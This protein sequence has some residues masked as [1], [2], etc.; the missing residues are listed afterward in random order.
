M[1]GSRFSFLTRWQAVLIM[2]LTVMLIVAGSEFSRS[3]TPSKVP[4]PST[5]E[6]A[7][8]V[9]YRQFITRVAQGDAYYP[10]AADELRRGNYP[11]RPFV[12]FRLPLLTEVSAALGTDVMLGLLWG[13]I[14][15]TSLA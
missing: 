6:D 10:M 4:T 1:S 13:L 14:G 3:G 11:L 8:L 7:D 12:A 2:L 15:A 5:S 9:L